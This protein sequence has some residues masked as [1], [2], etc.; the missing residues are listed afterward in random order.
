MGGQGGRWKT[1]THADADTDADTDAYCMSNRARSSSL[2]VDI[3]L[4]L[5]QRLGNNARLCYN[6]A[7]TAL[8]LYAS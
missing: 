5:V 2:F 1:W 3:M 4:R 8:A 7:F 6:A